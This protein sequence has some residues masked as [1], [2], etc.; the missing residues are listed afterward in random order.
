M[1]RVVCNANADMLVGDE[2][3]VVGCFRVFGKQQIRF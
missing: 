2:K 1:R 3:R